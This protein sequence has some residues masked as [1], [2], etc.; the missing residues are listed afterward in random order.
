[1]RPARFI[2][3][4]GAC[5]DAPARERGLS[6][7]NRKQTL[8]TFMETTKPQ[9]LTDMEWI[10]T[11]G[12]FKKISESWNTLEPS[13]KKEVSD[14]LLEDKDFKLAMM[15]RSITCAPQTQAE[16]FVD[17]NKNNKEL[18]KLVG[19]SMISVIVGFLISK[20]EQK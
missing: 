17:I 19:I 12:G 2:D 18:W 7:S 13:L 4:E 9:N 20:C 1:M 10:N 5:G 3:D 14:L 16:G 11:L 8:N 15:S 6:R